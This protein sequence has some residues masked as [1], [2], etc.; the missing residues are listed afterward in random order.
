MTYIEP[1]WP[2]AQIDREIRTP[3]S[4]EIS[5]NAK[6]EPSFSIKVYCEVGE[7]DSAKAKAIRLDREL[8]EELWK[9]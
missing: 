3:S 6:R 7:E 8:R 5:R 1:T 2:Y 4:I 9:E